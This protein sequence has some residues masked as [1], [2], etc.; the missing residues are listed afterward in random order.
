MIAILAERGV[1]DAGAIDARAAE[2]VR[3]RGH[4][5]S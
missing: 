3:E 1:V 4:A 2:I 5:H